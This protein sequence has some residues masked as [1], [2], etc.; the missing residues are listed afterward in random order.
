MVCATIQKHELPIGLITDMLAVSDA[1]HLLVVADSCYSGALTPVA[2]QPPTELLPAEQWQARA[3]VRTEGSWRVAVTSGGL[4]PV[5]GTRIQRWQGFHL[6]QRLGARACRNPGCALNP[7]PV[8][9]SETAHRQRP[10]SA[11]FRPMPRNG[12]ATVRQPRARR[13]VLCAAARLIQRSGRL[14]PAEVTTS[15]T[16]LAAN[17]DPPARTQTTPSGR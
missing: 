2:A 12:P 7:T 16:R 4:R 11:I 14:S 6:C 5:P 15:R 3:D 1:R 9:R 8:P 10:R 17:S 13:I